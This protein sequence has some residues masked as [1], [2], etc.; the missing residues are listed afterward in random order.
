ALPGVQAAA[1]A[2]GVPMGGAGYITFAIDGRAA[3]PA[4]G[5]DLQPF[6]VSP[7][8]FAALRIPLRSGRLFTTADAGDAPDVAVINE[9][10][11]RRFFDGRDPVG[12][13]ITFGDPANPA[14]TWRTVVGVVG[15]VAQEGVTAAPYPQLYMPIAQS[16]SR[17]VVVELRTA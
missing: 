6:S 11:A 1:V 4:G 17:S 5:E 7:E 12:R 8:H 15:D 10:M 14:S 16:P 2:N 3:P 9:E 13:R